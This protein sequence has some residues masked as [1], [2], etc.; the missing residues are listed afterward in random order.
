MNRFA[1]PGF[2]L[3]EIIFVLA[4]IAILAVIIIPMGFATIRDSEVLRANSD[5]DSLEAALLVFLVNL[6]GHFPS[7]SSSL[8]CNPLTS[9]NN[10]L[11][12]LVFLA[13]DRPLDK[14]TNTALIP[15]KSPSVACNTNMTFRERLTVFGSSSLSTH[16]AFNHLMVND[17]IVDLLENSVSDYRTETGG[18]QRWNGPYLSRL[19]LDPWGNPYVFNVGGAEPNGEGG[20][21]GWLISAGPNGLFDTCADSTRLNTGSPFGGSPGA[22]TPGGD[23]IGFI[24]T[25]RRP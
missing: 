22:R 9:N 21:Q 16:N 14:A 10:D 11:S 6:G 2:T 7:C 20:G 24:I 17:P 3:I 8:S 5:L 1:Q 25:K 13:D 4:I 18:G 19:N 12:I 15:D 23:D